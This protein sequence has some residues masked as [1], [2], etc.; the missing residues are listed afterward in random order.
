ML[1]FLTSHTRKLGTVSLT[2]ALG[3]FLGQF[4]I[5]K[6][7]NPYLAI[8]EVE[9]HSTPVWIQIHGLPLIHMKEKSILNVAA[10]VGSVLEHELIQSFGSPIF[11][12]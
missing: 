12:E 4:L 11:S 7:W 2:V 5:L 9:I 6:P 8:Y 10:S 1:L 3:V